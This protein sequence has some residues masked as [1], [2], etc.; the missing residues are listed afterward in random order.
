MKSVLDVYYRI[1]RKIS[2]DGELQTQTK[3][4]LEIKYIIK[5]NESGKKINTTNDWDIY[6]LANKK[7]IESWN[8][9][10][11]MERY[12]STIKV[13]TE[14]EIS[15]ITKFENPEIHNETYNDNRQINLKK[16]ARQINFSS[17]KSNNKLDRL[18]FVD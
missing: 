2:Y 5:I 18:E 7:I 15:K 14:D 16:D 11:Q 8:N 4:S 13:Y 12:L 6:T 17:D 9:S 3:H 1:K 10:Y